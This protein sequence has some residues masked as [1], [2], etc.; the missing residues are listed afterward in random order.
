[1][2]YTASSASFFFHLIF[3]ISI[4]IGK[5]SPTAWGPCFLTHHDDLKNLGRFLKFSI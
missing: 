1:M 5:I 3:R 2:L 4:N